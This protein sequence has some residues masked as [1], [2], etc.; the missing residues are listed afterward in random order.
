MALRPVQLRMVRRWR[1][2]PRIPCSAPRGQPERLT[3]LGVGRCS[4]SLCGIQIAAT[5]SGCPSY[6]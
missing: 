1:M 2:Q 3:Q 4:V 5:G 6:V